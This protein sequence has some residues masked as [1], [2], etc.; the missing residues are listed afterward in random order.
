MTYFNLDGVGGISLMLQIHIPC[1]QT[2][3][4]FKLKCWILKFIEIK[5]LI[6]GS[7]FFQEVILLRMLNFILP[8][9]A[10]ISVLSIKRNNC[11]P[12]S[13][14]KL[15]VVSTLNIKFYFKL[16]LKIKV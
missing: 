2:L 13:V 3:V 16:M 8:R 12:C 4:N 15:R 14:F 5:F 6:S 10:L 1:P 9:G 11:I 7:R